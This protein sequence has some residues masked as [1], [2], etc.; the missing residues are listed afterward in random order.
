M[1]E[2][3]RGTKRINVEIKL[4]EDEVKREIKLCC[5]SAGAIQL[6]NNILEHKH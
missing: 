1:R 5:S 3:N 2:G 4:V 6:P